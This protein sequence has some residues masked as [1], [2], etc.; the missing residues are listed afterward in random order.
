M[1]LVFEVRVCTVLN[2]FVQFHLKHIVI[3]VQT[4]QTSDIVNEVKVHSDDLDP[5]RR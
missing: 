4:K 2:L 5:W 1:K 3:E